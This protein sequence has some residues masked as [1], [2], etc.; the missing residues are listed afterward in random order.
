MCDILGVVE[1]DYFGLCY[2]DKYGLMW[3]NK[4]VLLKRQLKDHR[5]PY[6]FDMRVKFY[7]PPDNLQQQA[8]RWVWVVSTPITHMV[9]HETLKSGLSSTAPCLIRCA[10]PQSCDGHVTVTLYYSHGD[11]ISV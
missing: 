7:V 3:L 4:R 5:P 2:K 8:T 6:L 1:T 10:M 9:T 11:M